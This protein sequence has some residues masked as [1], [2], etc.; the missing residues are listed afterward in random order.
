MH[1]EFL[2]LVLLII[3]AVRLTQG[4]YRTSS[5]GVYN[6]EKWNYYHG[7]KPEAYSYYYRYS[8]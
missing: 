1:N 4:C 2:D 8:K 3:V 7:T 5:L 6:F